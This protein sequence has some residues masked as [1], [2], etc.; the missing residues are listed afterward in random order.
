ME[1]IA[2]GATLVLQSGP[3][4]RHLRIFFPIVALD[5]LKCLGVPDNVRNTK[6]LAIAS[7]TTTPDAHP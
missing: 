5:W 2:L 1:R 6:A 4:L 7:T 3:E